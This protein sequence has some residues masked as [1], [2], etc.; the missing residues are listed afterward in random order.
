MNT[1]SLILSSVLIG[2]PV[3]ISYKEKIIYGKGHTYKH[4]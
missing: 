3:F 2:I 4:S 1:Q